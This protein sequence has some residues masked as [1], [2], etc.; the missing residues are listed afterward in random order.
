M[1]KFIPGL[2]LCELFYQKEIRPILEKEFPRLRY[3][4]ALIGWG[5]EVLGFDTPLSRDHHWGPR[6]LLF[7][8]LQDYVRFKDKI[9]HSFSDNLPYEFL[10]SS[11][12]YSEP[13]ADGVRHAVKIERGRVNHMVQ[14]FT[15][16]SFFEARLGFD[17]TKKIRVVDWL[18]VPQQKLLEVVRG[19]V[20]HDGLGKLR[21]VREKLEFYP[22][23]L[24]LYLLAA[25][26]TKISQEEAF[27][28]RTGDAGDELG[29]SVVAARLVHE[30]MR[31]A[32][33]LERQYAPYA[34]W[35]G[36][37]FGRLKIGPRLTPVLQGVLVAKTWKAREKK[38][39]EAYSI[40]AA[41]HNALG[42]TKPL[43]IKVTKYYDRPF[44]VIH[45]DVFARAI[46]EAI[47]DSEVKDLRPNVGSVD[48]YI[49]SHEV[50][51]QLSMIKR[52]RV[53][54]APFSPRLS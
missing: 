26:W 23:D 49:D 46:R 8:N 30:I 38:L 41:Q 53:A 25:Q 10:G 5:S 4:A 9:S 36:T 13:D 32:F 31:L 43:P 6:M 12:N 50:L 15:L 51:Q 39:A 17:P 29:S 11:T 45:G 37:A 34:K 27:V 35:M 22:R 19:E 44:L 54:Y 20:Y 28:G 40:V 33:L 18:T 7:L 21:E 1:P 14:I 48:Q 3:S 2:K 24:W 42:I 47:R 16:K 52:L